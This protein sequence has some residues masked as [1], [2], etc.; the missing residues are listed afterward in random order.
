LG[1]L[2]MQSEPS[3]AEQALA[4]ALPFWD[5][6]AKSFADEPLYAVRLAMTRLN[7]ATLRHLTGRTDAADE[8]YGQAAADLER[9]GQPYPGVEEQRR[10]LANAYVNWGQLLRQQNRPQ[11][12]EEVWRKSIALLEGLAHDYP[13][14]IEHR[15]RLGLSQNELAIALSM[16]GHH[17]EAETE[18]G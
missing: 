4:Q 14:V 15:R 2:R 3:R 16:T 1:G 12:A 8:D 5:G 7:R 13:S 10:L 18:W 11:K 17:S 6:L 9:L